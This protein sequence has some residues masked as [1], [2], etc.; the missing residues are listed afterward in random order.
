MLKVCV[1]GVWYTN[2]SLSTS[3]RNQCNSLC[4]QRLL[5]SLFQHTQSV[6]GTEAFQV[7]PAYYQGRGTENRHWQVP[8]SLPIN[9]ETTLGTDTQFISNPVK[10]PPHVTVKTEVTH[11]RLSLRKLLR[12]MLKSIDQKSSE[13]LQDVEDVAW[14]LCVL[15]KENN[16]TYRF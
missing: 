7:N 2:L 15:K 10:K 4:K 12:K 16:A 13:Q 3:S 6:W 8:Q 11:N 14:Q 5:L 9:Q 1:W